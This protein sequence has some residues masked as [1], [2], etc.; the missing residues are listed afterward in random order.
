M[1]NKTII[2]KSSS[3]YLPMT[4]L[5][6]IAITG[7]RE[8]TE[9]MDPTTQK[10]SVTDEPHPIVSAPAE[11]PPNDKPKHKHSIF[12]G[13]LDRIGFLLANLYWGLILLA[14]IGLGFIL[15]NVGRGAV[16]PNVIDYLF[17]I[18]VIILLVVT[19]IFSVGFLIRRFHDVGQ[20]GWFALLTLIPGAGSVLFI[21]LLILPGTDGPNEYGEAAQGS[22]GFRDVSGL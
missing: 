22:F 10:T 1:L 18:V 5:L 13:R 7:A 19:A 9:L 11:L 4:M 21:V 12:S 2:P 8:Y 20:S 16:V 14:L 3:K 6:I 15:G 17:G